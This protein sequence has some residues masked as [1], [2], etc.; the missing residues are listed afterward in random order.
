MSFNELKIMIVWCDDIDIEDFWKDFDHQF[1]FSTLNYGFFLLNHLF[2]E[3][4][5]LNAN[6]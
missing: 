5:N 3:N 1:F 4:N 2:I 6:C